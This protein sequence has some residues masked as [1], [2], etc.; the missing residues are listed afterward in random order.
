M[1]ML[2]MSVELHVAVDRLRKSGLL[3]S[4]GFVGGKWIDAYDGMTLQVQNPATG[5]VITSVPCM[6]KD[7]LRAN[8]LQV[9][10]ANF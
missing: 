8:S 4:Q 2:R 10:G 7:E 1:V 9:T 3:R 6:G 5:D